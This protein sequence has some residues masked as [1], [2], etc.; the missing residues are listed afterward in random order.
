MKPCSLKS[1][2]GAKCAGQRRGH[3][4]EPTVL[5]G[6]TLTEEVFG[7]VVAVTAFRTEEEALY[8]ANEQTKH[9][10]GA[11]LWTRDLKRAH[12]VMRKLRAGVVWCNAHH[13][14]APDAPWGGY[15][16]AGL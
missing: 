6:C 10:L 7:P 14:N 15:G 2:G 3:F 11:G 9:G 5:T 12:R 4:Y 8:L 16:V 13:R 1:P